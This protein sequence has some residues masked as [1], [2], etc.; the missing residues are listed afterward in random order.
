MTAVMG[1]ADRRSVRVG[2]T[3]Q[4]KV[5]CDGA[6]AYNATIVRLLS[7]QTFPP[8]HAPEFRFDV[9]TSAVNGEHKGQ[10]YPIPA[11]SY[12][13]IPANPK[14]SS[15][16]T[17]TLA[18][19]VWPT[20]P[21]KGEQAILGTT[22][23]NAA[24]GIG[25][26]I[27]GEGR[28]ALAI[29]DKR[30]ALP[31]KL[32]PKRWSFVAASLDD[33]A[34]T[35]L[36]Y[37]REVELFQFDAQGPAETRFDHVPAPAAG[38]RPFRIGAAAEGLRAVRHYN[39]RI[40][41]PRVLGRALAAH[42]LERLALAGPTGPA[43]VDAVADWDFSRDI[44]SEI[45]SDL[46]P[47]GLWGQ[48]V[49][50]PTRA[51]AGS[52]WKAERHDWRAIPEQYG[53][54]HFHDD[55]IYDALWP[56]AFE[57]EIP[58]GWKSGTYACRL[59]AGD[60]EYW[61]PFFI[62]PRKGAARARCA[63]LVPTCTYAAYANFRSR[64]EGRWSELYHGRVTVLDRT[65][66]LME[67]YSD[68][69][70]S[71]YDPHSDG[72]LTLYS[73]MLRPVTNYRPTGRVYKFCQ[74]MFFIAWLEQAGIDYEVVTDDDL[75][76]E[77]VS[78]ISDYACIFTGSHPEYYTT[79]MLDAVESFLRDGGRFMYLGGNGF[80]WRTA[81]HPTLPGVVEVR[82]AGQGFLASNVEGESHM[83][84]TGEVAGTWLRVGRPPNLIAGVGMV[85]QGFDACT[86]YRR[87]KASHDPRAAFIFEG[88][89]EEIVGDFGVLMGGAAGYEIDRHDIGLGSPRH[90]LLLAS[91]FNHTNVYDVS[92]PSFMDLVPKQKED[93]LDPVRADI[94]FFETPGGG[95]VFSVGSIAWSGSLSWNNYDNNIERITQN[96]LKRFI[97][98]T[99]FR[100]PEAGT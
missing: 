42:D 32:R 37:A 29:G 30:F 79:E 95:A 44:G 22:D 5:S 51:V 72:S 80:Y 21:G 57:V 68:L 27:D 6:P 73:S 1:Y 45:V 35:A 48:T 49:N 7:A 41:R 54:I 3:I 16:A 83:S 13:E 96:V 55:D 90:A 25:L 4:F 11:G 39:G 56:T 69:G 81:Y 14:L 31:R 98:P 28:L 65:D 75:H 77:G 24:G 20:L 18:A 67:E 33:K 82:R 50:L 43:H 84:F 62:R 47:N 19:F 100:M 17:C 89:K 99:S 38:P 53:A 12:A 36:L 52:N 70:S 23:A 85:T 10:H 2:E 92:V 60:S 78:A 88:V 9:M 59:Q 66:F 74:D 93:D 58:D 63:F 61:V 94:V 15:L 46:S 97:D 40:E 87:A 71:T 91:S 26:H 64:V 8:P 76:C 86:G 34:G